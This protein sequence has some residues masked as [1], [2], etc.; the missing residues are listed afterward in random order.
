MFSVWEWLFP[1]FPRAAGMHHTLKKKVAV[2]GIADP[3]PPRGGAGGPVVPAAASGDLRGGVQRRTDG[4][5]ARGVQ[6]RGIEDWKGLITHAIISGLVIGSGTLQL[7]PLRV[8][9]TDLKVCTESKGHGE[10]IPSR[11]PGATPEAQGARRSGRTEVGARGLS[12][13]R[14]PRGGKGVL[15]RNGC[16]RGV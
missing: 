12:A 8:P 11:W 13:R 3:G 1:A 4:Q 16:L 10:V 6:T 2:L 15:S 5:R 9:G 14:N 7:S